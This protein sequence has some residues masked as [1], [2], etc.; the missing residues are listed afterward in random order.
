MPLR[1]NL[2]VN[3][4]DNRVFMSRNYRSDSCP[5]KFDVLKT[6]IFALEASLQ[7]KES[8]VLNLRDFLRNTWMLSSTPRTQAAAAIA[9]VNA[10]GAFCEK[11]N[12]PCSV[13]MIIENPRVG[14]FKKP[15]VIEVPVI[16]HPELK[17]QVRALA[18]EYSRLSEYLL[19]TEA[20]QSVSVV[21]IF[22]FFRPSQFLF[23][24]KT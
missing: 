13:N 11:R 3:N 23:K 5:W 24:H 18:C 1:E 2:V 15:T 21:L 17:S 10:K 19:R 6:S 7:E 9:P 22:R 14:S 8:T 4:K 16:K 20:W 12:W